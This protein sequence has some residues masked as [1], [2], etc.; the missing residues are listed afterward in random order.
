MVMELKRYAYLPDIHCGYEYDEETGLFTTSHD[1]ALLGKVM[2]F[3]ARFKP[4]YL[5]LGGDQINLSCISRWTVGKPKMVEGRRIEE[6]YE[7]FHRLVWKPLSKINHIVKVIWIEGNHEERLR[8]LSLK[9]PQISGLLTHTKLL[10]TVG[11]SSTQMEYIHTGK[12]WRPP[13]AKVYFLHGHTYSAGSNPAKNLVE[14]YARSVRAG[15]FHRH[16]SWTRNVAADSEDYH[17]SIVSPP[18]CRPNLPYAKNKPS[19]N[20]QGFMVGHYDPTTGFFWDQVLQVVAG[21]FI[22]D[23]K[24]Y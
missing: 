4:D 10:E 24:V 9:H 20:Q 19:S 16:A 7:F 17:T 22:Y 12:L 23:G 3:M 5:I 8:E 2:R 13:N 21:T 14:A 6:D 1:E 11:I 18:L 15:H